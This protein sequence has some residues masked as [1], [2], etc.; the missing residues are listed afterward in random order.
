ME[1]WANNPETMIILDTLRQR[2]TEEEEE[3][4][5]HKQSKRKL[6]NNFKLGLE[7]TDKNCDRR[8]FFI[9]ER[10]KEQNYRDENDPYCG[11]N[12]QKSNPLS[13]MINDNSA[14]TDS[15][16]SNADLVDCTPKFTP[17]EKLNR[18]RRA[19]IFA[20]YLVDHFGKEFLSSGV[21][22]DVA[23]G[24]GEVS[25]YL[26]TE[27]HIKSIVIDP[28]E[29]TLSEKQLQKLQETGTSLQYIHEYFTN[30]E[31][32]WSVQFRELIMNSS[33]IVGLHPDQATEAIIDVS[34]RYNKAAV[35]VPCCVFPSL[36]PNRKLSSGE[37]VINYASFIEYLLEKDRNKLELDFL[38][39]VGMNK[40]VRSKAL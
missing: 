13:R 26:W 16:F 38:P 3:T 2:Y 1:N 36:F 30:S 23:G 32:D 24:K 37:N 18:T 31:L 28:R 9:N 17:V 4:E 33:I 8:H 25:F 34:L 5:S 10:E 20:K 11:I 21:V 22:L 19:Q 29:A 15:R 12:F 40:I 6:C 27:Y 14:L 7:C 39:V 35:V